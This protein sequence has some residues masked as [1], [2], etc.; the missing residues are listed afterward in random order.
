MMKFNFCGSL[1]L[2]NIQYCFKSFFV[3][4]VIT[5]LP[6]QAGLPVAVTYAK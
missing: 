3:Q 5:S 4:S 1:F 2:F 6:A